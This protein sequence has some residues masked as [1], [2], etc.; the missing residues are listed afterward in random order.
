MNT[1]V[2]A[3]LSPRLESGQAKPDGVNDTEACN[4]SCLA[5]AVTEP[6]ESES[7]VTVAEA[8]SEADAYAEA[9]CTIEDGDTKQAE[10]CEEACGSQALAEATQFGSMSGMFSVSSIAAASAFLAATA[11]NAALVR[12]GEAPLPSSRHP[13]PS[14]LLLELQEGD[15]GC[16][17]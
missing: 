14:C 5:A 8:K 4:P 17:S 15:G 9:S 10:V 12:F 2:A 1:A 3:R 6:G 13:T 11:V 16:D 7:G